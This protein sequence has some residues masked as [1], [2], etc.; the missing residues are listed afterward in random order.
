M[1]SSVA[2]GRSQGPAAVAPS[3]AVQ[4]KAADPKPAPA[5]PV[6]PVVPVVPGEVTRS[7]PTASEALVRAR[8]LHLSLDG[9]LQVMHRDFFRRN[10]SKA[11]PSRSLADVF[12][13]LEEKEGVKLRWL[14]AEETIMNSD[15][16]AVDEF[17][18]KALE[19]LSAEVSEHSAVQDSTLRFTGSIALKNECLKCHVPHRTQLGDRFAALEITIPIS[20]PKQSA[21]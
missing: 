5:A 21:E 14:A 17:Q 4:E 1:L 8:L 2:T 6:V 13:V 10:D 3:V 16:A 18:K 15:H 19:L 11:I 12:K 9:A 7:L 20:A